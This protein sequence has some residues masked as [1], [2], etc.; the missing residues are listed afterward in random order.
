MY[1]VRKSAVQFIGQQQQ[2][3]QL[4]Y[5]FTDTPAVQFCRVG[6]ANTNQQ[7]WHYL[8]EA[9]WSQLNWQESVGGMWTSRDDRR[10]S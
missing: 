5:T 7:Q 4:A 10:S 9:A 6:I 8:A 2:L 1:I 3:D